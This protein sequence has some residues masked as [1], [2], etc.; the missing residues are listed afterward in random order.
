MARPAEQEPVMDSG[1]TQAEVADELAVRNVA[2]RIARYSDEGELEDYGRQFT[3]DAR[4]AMPGVVPVRHSRAEIVAAGAARRATGET[5][6]GSAGRHVVGTTAVT[7]R[8]DT[9]VAD[10]SW[11]FYVDTTTSPK[12]RLM[13]AY[14]ARSGG[15]REAGNSPNDSSR[16]AELPAGGAATGH[17]CPAPIR[18]PGRLR[19]CGGAAC[20]RRARAWPPSDLPLPPLGVLCRRVLGA[21]PAARRVY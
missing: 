3:E 9:A 10:S 5:G 17:E 20:R 11:Q 13:G 16:W 21:G 19:L 8:G 7:V 15:R 6:P 2:A 18:P 14:R 1:S 12:L 4:W